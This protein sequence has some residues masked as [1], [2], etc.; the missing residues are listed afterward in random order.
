MATNVN[1]ILLLQDVNLTGVQ[2]VTRAT[3]VTSYSPGVPVAS[4]DNVGV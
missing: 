1:P 4:T 3:A 2:N